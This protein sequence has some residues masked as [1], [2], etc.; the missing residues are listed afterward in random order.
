VK[1]VQIVPQLPPAVNGLG[2]YAHVLGQKLA[3]RFE[4]RSDFIVADPSWKPEW[5]K[6]QAVRLSSR[7]A[8]VLPADLNR[9]EAEIV[10]LHYVGYGYAKRGCPTWL[11]DGLREWKS[12][13]SS[14]RLITIFHE[15]Y[16]TGHAWQSSFWLSHFQKSLAR[17]LALLSDV[18][19]TTMARYAGIVRA[20][21]PTINVTALPVFS[22]IGETNNLPA[23]SARKRQLVVFAGA[24]LRYEIYSRHLPALLR[25]GRALEIEKIVDIGPSIGMN[26]GLPLPFEQLGVQSAEAVRKI[27]ANSVAGFL[28]Y[29]DGYLAKSSVFAAYCAHAMVPILPEKNRSDLDGLEVGQQYLSGSDISSELPAHIAQGV[30]DRAQ[31]WYRQHSIE[32][33]ASVI[34]DALRKS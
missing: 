24:P 30:A 6:S 34:A 16:A 4:I 17:N 5:T 8:T 22:A 12:R 9:T 28:F 14:R 2:D 10:L 1:V 13:S 18:A 26:V 31:N 3:E 27:L 33:T 25:V 19:H 20:W 23:L 29:Y 11:V 21:N 32:N 7:S 15:L